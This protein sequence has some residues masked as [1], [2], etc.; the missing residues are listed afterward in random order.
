L[1]K[2]YPDFEPRGRFGIGDRPKLKVTI[3]YGTLE[4]T[5]EGAADEVL[6]FVFQFIR[7]IYPDYEIVNGLVLTADLRELLRRLKGIVSF[8]PK[9]RPVIL[10]STSKL[11]DTDLILTHLVA[12]FAGNQI[13]IAD[14]D[15]LSMAELLDKMGKSAG[16]IAGRLSELVSSVYVDRVGRGEYRVTQYGVKKFMEDVLPLLEGVK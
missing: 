4:S 5:C 8:L 9:G 6:K 3:R 2:L 11:K 1:K 15:K 16:T 10:K 7:D 14:R 12:V 13:G